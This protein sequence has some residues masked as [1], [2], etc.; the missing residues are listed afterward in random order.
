M[1]TVEPREWVGRAAHPGTLLR[2]HVLPVLSLSVTQA[3]RD[4]GV[5]RQTLHRILSGQAGISPDMALRLQRFCGVPG[6]VWL[7]RQNEHD[8][9]RLDP[10]AV[11]TTDYPIHTLPPEMLKLIGGFGD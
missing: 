5:T 3:S 10:A 9:D 4:L 7:M 6:R 1:N 2:R 8:L 11:E